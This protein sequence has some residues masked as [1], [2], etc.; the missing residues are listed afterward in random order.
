M[1][2]TFKTIRHYTSR[3]TNQQNHLGALI[4]IEIM[5]NDQDSIYMA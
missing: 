3:T 5:M 1:E 2:A 4:D